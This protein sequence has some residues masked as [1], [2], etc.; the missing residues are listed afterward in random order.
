MIVFA[1]EGREN[2]GIFCTVSLRDPVTAL[3]PLEKPERSQSP[4]VRTGW[5]F[6]DHFA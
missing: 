1:D 2:E 3:T 4:H 6:M 5:R